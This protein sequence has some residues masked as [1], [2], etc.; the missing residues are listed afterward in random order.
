MCSNRLQLNAEKT[1][2]MGCTST[3]KLSQ[4]PRSP[5]PVAGTPVQPVSGVRDLGVFI[6]NDHH[7]RPENCVTVSR[8]YA[9]FVTSA[10]T[11]LMTVS[12][13]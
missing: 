1:E 10:V 5:V 2:V 4:L 7:P 3:R 9:N 12:V 6:D 13:C 8:R 11:S